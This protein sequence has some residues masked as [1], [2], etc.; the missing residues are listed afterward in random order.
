MLKSYTKKIDRAG[1]SLYIAHFKKKLTPDEELSKRS[2]WS[3]TDDTS[4]KNFVWNA[5]YSLSFSFSTDCSN[6]QLRVSSTNQLGTNSGYGFVE[7]EVCRPV[8]CAVQVPIQ[9]SIQLS[10]DPPSHNCFSD[11]KPPTYCALWPLSRILAM[12]MRLST[13]S[14]DTWWT[15]TPLSLSLPRTTVVALVTTSASRYGST[16]LLFSAQ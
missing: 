9:N 14:M 16:Y 11:F 7:Y 15:E 13:S 2:N 1:S 4:F 6:M 12:L 3:V 8:N 10:L 5:Q